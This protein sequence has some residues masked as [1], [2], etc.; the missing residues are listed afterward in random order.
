M[1]GIWKKFA[2]DCG[3]PDDMDDKA[4]DILM[5][6]FAADN[7]TSLWSQALTALVLYEDVPDEGAMR[8]QGDAPHIHWGYLVRLVSGGAADYV[9]GEYHISYAPHKFWRLMTAQWRMSRYVL[10]KTKN[11]V[12]LPTTDNEQIVESLALG[13][14]LLGLTFRLKNM[15]ETALAAALSDPLQL[16]M[17]VRQTIT[18]M[19]AIQKRRTALSPAWSRLFP[20][21]HSTQ[22]NID[23]GHAPR[24]ISDNDTWRGIGVCGND[25]VGRA[26]FLNRVSDFKLLDKTSDPLVLIFA[27]ARPETVELFGHAVAVLY[28]DGGVMSHACT[29]S[30]ETNFPCITALGQEAVA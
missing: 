28:G 24:A 22:K 29:I 20:I 30:R 18:Q 3:L 4:K 5:N 23:V 26:V 21:H 25:V 15:D 13:I 1:T 9:D 8:W 2:D 19:Q 7:T 6:V 12:P 16:P 17:S 27:R 14:C 10:L 11:N